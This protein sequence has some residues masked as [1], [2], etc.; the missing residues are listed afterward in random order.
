MGNLAMG[1]SATVSIQATALQPGSIT[2]TATVSADESDPAPNNN[3]ATIGTTIGQSGYLTVTL[4]PQAAIAAGAKWQVDNGSWQASGTTLSNIGTGSHTVTFQNVAGL[5][6]PANQT[7]TVS[8]GRTTSAAGT[9]VQQTGSL[10]VAISPQAAVDE[11]A[12]W[13][14]DSGGWQASGSEISNVP[15]G[16]HTVSFKDVTGWT[17]PGNVGVTVANGQTATITGTYAQ[18]AGSLVLTITPVA[19]VQAGARWKLDSGAWQPSGAIITILPPGSHTV[20]FN[21]VAGWIANFYY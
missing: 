6:S 4:S 9:Y 21:N 12:Q 20:T 1:A 10:I 15:I 11:G 2:N 18:Q 14:M 19:A 13:Q 5:T 8:N 7:V 16:P 3:S 17:T